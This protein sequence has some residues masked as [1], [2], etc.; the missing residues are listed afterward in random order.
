MEGIPR[1]TKCETCRIGSGGAGSKR[2]NSAGANKTKNRETLMHEVV[3][4][5][6]LIQRK[7]KKRYG[8]LSQRLFVNSPTSV[9]YFLLAKTT[10]PTRCTGNERGIHNK[11]K[12]A[13]EIRIRSKEREK[14]RDVSHS[15]DQLFFFFNSWAPRRPRASNRHENYTAPPR[16]VGIFRL[17]F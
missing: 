4:Q 9:A 10:L 12:Q 1:K 2:G 14:R 15:T 8:V 3:Y 6:P 17:W 13:D 7:E 5:L 16:S 11:A